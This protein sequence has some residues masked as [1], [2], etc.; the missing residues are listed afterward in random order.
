LDPNASYDFL[1]GETPDQRLQELRQQKAMLSQ[2]DKSFEA[3]APGLTDAEK[4]SFQE[5]VKI[6]GEVTAMRWLV[7][8]H[9]NPQNSP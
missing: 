3:I 2:L 9:A 6:Y 5:R 1:G 8:Q 4:V 7:Q